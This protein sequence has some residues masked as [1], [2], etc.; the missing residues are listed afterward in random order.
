M[1]ISREVKSIGGNRIVNIQPRVTY[2]LTWLEGLKRK[3]SYY[4]TYADAV[5]KADTVEQPKI[6]PVFKERG[7]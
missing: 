7:E 2:H 6:T 4:N 5:K 3:Y 1:V